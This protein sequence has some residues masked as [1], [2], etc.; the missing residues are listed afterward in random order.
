M[1]PKTLIAS[2]V[3]FKLIDDKPLF[4]APDWLRALQAQDYPNLHILAY[5]NDLDPERL[6][7]LQSI[8]ERGT[9]IGY[10]ALG[11]T[12]DVRGRG[13]RRKDQYARFAKIRNLVLDYV[14]S[15]DVEY[16]VSIDS[17]IIV[18]PNLVS[19]FVEH[20]ESKPNYGMIAAAI[21]NTRRAKM[22]LKHP[23][24]VYNFGRAYRNRPKDEPKCRAYKDFKRGEFIDVDYT[25]A[26]CIIRVKMLRAHTEIRW[27]EHRQ[28][29]DLYFSAAIQKAGWKIG[30]DTSL[31]GLHKMDHETWKEDVEAFERGEIV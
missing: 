18:H 21:N 16:F 2:P 1:R 5:C 29:E 27:G 14:L 20:M 3:S 15:T 4:T 8:A 12:P 6:S 9:S 31:V 24:A 10:A 23:R 11:N 7:E 26:C 13:T 25:G 19:K 17:D 28:G 22:K 30:V